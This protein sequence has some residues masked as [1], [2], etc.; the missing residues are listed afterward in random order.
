MRVFRGFHQPAAS[1]T[2]LTLGNFDGVHRGHRV[3]L[4]RLLEQGR[5]LAATAAVVTFE[6]HPREFFA[7]DSA[8]ARL[9]TLR[10]KLEAFAAAGVDAVYVTPFNAAFAA[11][12]AEAFVEDLLCK[13]LKAR[14]VIIGD[15]FRF[16]AGR[17]GNFACLQAAGHA[18]GFGVEALPTVTLLGERVSSSAVRAAL[19]AGDLE[20][21][22]NFLERPY[23]IAGQVVH[24]QKLGRQ[25]GFATANI[26]IRHNPLPMQ[27][28][29]AV[30]ASGA[31]EQP[32]LGVANLGLRPTLN[33]A[34]A[35]ATRPLLEVHLLDFSGNLY[36]AHLN[37]AFLKKLRDEM[38]FPHLDAL[39]TRIAAD[40]RAARDF[41]A[42]HS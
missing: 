14:H 28:V 5:D 23:A 21:A 15:D 41:F 36:G 25:L 11:R 24:G 16:G 10:E 27:G 34:G 42:S 31:G 4:A 22:A 30:A 9:S 6:P 8:P 3:L 17:L 39:K 33:P 29:F 37:I 35:R 32:L 7:P 2:V 1:A 26:R 19:A 13:N 20:K 40:V 38:T 18:L 12:S